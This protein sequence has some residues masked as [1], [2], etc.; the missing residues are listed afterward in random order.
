[1]FMS[2]FHREVTIIG[3]TML[4]GFAVMAAGRRIA[5]QENSVSSKPPRSSEDEAPVA[6]KQQLRDVEERKEYNSLIAE[7]AAGNDMES[8][9]KILQTMLA[10]NVKPNKVTYEH[11]LKALLRRIRA[12]QIEPGEAGKQAGHLMLRLKLCGMKPD[13]H[14]FKLLNQIYRSAGV[15]DKIIQDI[16]LTA[17][18][19][20]S[21]RKAQMMMNC[22]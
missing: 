13:I 10:L 19:S 2:T 9:Y 1:M 22:T 20:K 18:G 11:F 7:A 6:L 5:E 12:D 4:F 8:M 15:S 21:R 3:V 16:P 17:V 14:T